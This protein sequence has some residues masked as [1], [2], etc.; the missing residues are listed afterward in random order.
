MLQ[1]VTA[2]RAKVTCDDA[3]SKRD[4]MQVTC[5]NITVVCTCTESLNT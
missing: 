2:L 3:N 5:P 1:A 4:D